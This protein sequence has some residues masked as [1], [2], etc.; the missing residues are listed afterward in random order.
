MKLSDECLELIQKLSLKVDDIEKV[1]Q[2]LLANS[3]LDNI[4]ETVNRLQT[5]TMMQHESE[6]FF[7]ESERSINIEVSEMILSYGL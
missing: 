1:L 7:W 2:L 6:V 4:D 5:G 3:M